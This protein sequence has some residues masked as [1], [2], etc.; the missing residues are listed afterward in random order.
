[1]EWLDKRS[2]DKEDE[3]I[4]TLQQADL[5]EINRRLRIHHTDDG[6]QQR[7]K[8]YTTNYGLSYNFGTEEKPVTFLSLA[9]KYNNHGAVL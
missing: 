3:D 4:S 7:I 1:M 8:E 6:Y 5:I 9:L 2:S